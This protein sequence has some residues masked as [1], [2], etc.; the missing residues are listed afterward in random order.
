MRVSTRRGV[1]GGSAAGG[2]LLTRPGPGLG[3]RFLSGR[4]RAGVSRGRMRE[5][6]LVTRIDAAGN[7][8]GVGEGTEP[9]AGTIMIGSH[10]DTVA[11]AAGGLMDRGCD[12]GVGDC[13]GVE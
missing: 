11:W 4:A 3:R 12:C 7:L 6:G 10:S 8:I 9:S 1:L 2:R 13:C 5:L